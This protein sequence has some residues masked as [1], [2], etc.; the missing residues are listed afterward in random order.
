MK[1]VALPIYFGFFCSIPSFIAGNARFTIVVPANTREC[2]FYA[3]EK[4]PELEIEYKVRE[5]RVADSQ[6]GIGYLEVGTT[7]S[8]F[9]STS[10]GKVSYSW[11]FLRKYED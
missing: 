4:H 7:K 5:I 3:S 2:L 9:V 1:L 11:N 6:L 8:R 10:H